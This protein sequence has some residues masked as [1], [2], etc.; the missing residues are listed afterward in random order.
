MQVSLRFLRVV[1]M[2]IFAVYCLFSTY[3]VLS[4]QFHSVFFFFFC[5]DSRKSE[6][7]TQQASSFWRGLIRAQQMDM[8]GPEAEVF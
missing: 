2:V 1:K 3:I 6:S 7:D 5:T 4:S 8:I